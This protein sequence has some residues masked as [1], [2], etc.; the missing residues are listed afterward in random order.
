MAK[1]PKQ[2]GRKGQQ[3][4]P[5]FIDYMWSIYKH[6]NYKGI[7]SGMLLYPVVDQDVRLQYDDLQGFPVRICTVN[8]ARD[9]QHIRAE[10]LSLVAHI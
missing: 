2:Y 3:W 10:L 8:L 9:W 7:V 6:P 5:A 4:H 1:Q